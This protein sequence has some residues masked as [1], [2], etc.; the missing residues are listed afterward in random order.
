MIRTNIQ[1]IEILETNF[2]KKKDD[3]NKHRLSIVLW[4]EAANP[5]YLVFQPLTM[6][7]ERIYLDAEYPDKSKEKNSIEWIVIGNLQQ[8][9][10]Y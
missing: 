5:M 8:Y 10:C 2:R 4:E 7:R 3:K 9:S 1:T 6:V